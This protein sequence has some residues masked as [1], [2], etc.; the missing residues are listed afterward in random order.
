[1]DPGPIGLSQMQGANQRPTA[2]KAVLPMH[3]SLC[4]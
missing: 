1:M 2:R 3:Y 4:P